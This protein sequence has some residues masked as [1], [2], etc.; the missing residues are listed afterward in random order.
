MD[1]KTLGDLDVAGK[2]VLVRA[3]FNVPIDTQDPVVT[4]DHDH[5]LRAT[6]PTLRYLIDRNCKLVLCSHLGRPKGRVVDSL[7]MAPIAKRLAHLISQP[8]HALDDC[9]GP[10][11]ASRVS[12]MKPRG[13]GAPGK[14]AV[15]PR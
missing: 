6:L 14:P 1:K 7:R 12:R 10:A 4:A 3:D 8:V 2:T 11:V 9:I 15:P 5:R 13:N